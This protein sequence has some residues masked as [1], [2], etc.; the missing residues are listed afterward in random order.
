MKEQYSFTTAH[1]KLA[2]T[3]SKSS[4]LLAMMLNLF[5]FLLSHCVFGNI[6]PS[7][8]SGLSVDTLTP[9]SVVTPAFSVH[10]DFCDSCILPA[11]GHTTARGKKHNSY[12]FKITEK[13]RPLN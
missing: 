12:D 10:R 7:L 9:L 2:D 11:G 1:T 5:F 8:S 3:W 13:K 4:K 6:I